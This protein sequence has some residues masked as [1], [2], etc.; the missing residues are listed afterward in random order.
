MELI[1]NFFDLF[2]HL[3]ANLDALIQNYGVWTY[4]ILFLII[5][6]ETGLVIMPFMPGDTL[7]FAAGAFVARGSLQIGLLF[8]LLAVAAIVGDTVNYWIGGIIGPRIFNKENVRFLNKKHLQRAHGFYEKY[9]GKTIVI[10]RFIPIIRTFA[11]FVAGMGKMNYMRFLTYNVC[12]A[13]AWIGLFL[14]GGFYFGNLPFVKQN[15]SILIGAI[16]LIS[17]LPIFVEWV[18]ERRK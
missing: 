13:A 11:P 12:G 7:L 8:T 10:A 9:G 17:L 14:F 15:F 4:V 16:I 3:D 6:F 18:R 5:F 2:V 1:R